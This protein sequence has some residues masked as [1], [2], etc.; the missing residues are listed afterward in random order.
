[1]EH[2]FQPGRHPDAGADVRES[3]PEE[4]N[5][6]EEVENAFD[7]PGCELRGEGNALANRD[8]PGADELAWAAEEYDRRKAD[9][10]GRDQAAEAYIGPERQHHYPPP[11]GAADVGKKY[12][13]ESGGRPWRIDPTEDRSE[14]IP[15]ESGS[16]EPDCRESNRRH[17]E[18]RNR[19]ESKPA[20]AQMVP[21]SFK[22][23]L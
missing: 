6:A 5:Y 19:D 18:Q 20:R 13:N 12:K 15:I 11:E 2:G 1:M 17:G 3:E 8:Q 23:V 10:G 22:P 21:I 16:A 4:E 7:E 9:G 14:Q